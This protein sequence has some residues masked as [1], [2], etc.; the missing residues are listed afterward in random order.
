MPRLSSRYCG[1][2]WYF[3]NSVCHSASESGGSA[4]A[5]GFHST[6]E[7]PDSVSRV[8]PPT[9][10]V[11]NIIVADK[12]SHSRT[13]RKRTPDALIG[14]CI[15]LLAED[16]ADH[17]DRGVALQ[18]RARTASYVDAHPQIGRHCRSFGA[19]HCLG[20]AGDGA[21]PVRPNRHQRLGGDDLLHRRWPWL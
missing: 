6:I 17:I 7:S 18:M 1:I 3:V 12:S 16:G 2:V 19:C 20:P 13:G 4:P 21:C 10:S 14:S 5:T 9:I 11:S 15:V 8:A